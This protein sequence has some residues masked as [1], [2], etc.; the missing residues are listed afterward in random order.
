MV[1]LAGNSPELRGTSTERATLESA[2]PNQIFWELDTND[3]YYWTG[4]AWAKIG[5]DADA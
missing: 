4:D 5:G 2:E 3:K 1:T